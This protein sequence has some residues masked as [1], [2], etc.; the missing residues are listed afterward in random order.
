[1]K[2]NTQAA[3]IAA[4]AA[5]LLLVVG[6][7]GVAGVD[8]FFELLVSWVGP[9][10]A[11][12][13]LSRVFGGIAALGGVA[14]LIGAYFLATDR[15]RT[16]R[17][18]IVLGSGAGLITLL[19]FLARNL[20]REDFSYLSAVLPAIVGVALGILAQWWAEPAPLLP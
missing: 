16:A 7:S 4:A 19:L 12:L 1:M 10:P 18:L 8:H 11:L 20:I 17:T 15:V 9:Q 3:F 6:Y 2:V 13:L 5:V 14:V